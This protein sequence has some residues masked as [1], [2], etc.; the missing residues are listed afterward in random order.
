MWKMLVCVAAL[1]SGCAGAAAAPDDAQ[2]ATIR[3]LDARVG[4][5]ERYVLKRDQ[6]D[7]AL[8][9]R[10][11]TV[12]WK[13]SYLQAR[14]KTEGHILARLRRLEGLVSTLGV[15]TRGWWC[16]HRMCGRTRKECTDTTVLTMPPG[17]P[18]E[19]RPARSAWCTESQI[20][21]QPTPCAD[22][23]STE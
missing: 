10:L 21:C 18:R 14:G 6:D 16:D 2:A 8:I 20:G 12:L 17:D 4:A 13:T 23:L 7:D 22:C 5:L 1:A 9:E 15:P 3:L 11:N 19:C